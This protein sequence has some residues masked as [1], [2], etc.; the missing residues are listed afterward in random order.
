M[1]F[2]T[3]WLTV[4]LVQC[5]APA[6]CWLRFVFFKAIMKK[7]LKKEEIIELLTSSHVKYS[8]SLHRIAVALTFR[9]QFFIPTVHFHKEHL[10]PPSQNTSDPEEDRI[11]MTSSFTTNDVRMGGS[12][13][14]A[15]KACNY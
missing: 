4:S 8:H 5:K 12:P 10:S 14:E 6:S 9:S 13:D 1:Y 7:T 15:L 11:G 2:S 3:S